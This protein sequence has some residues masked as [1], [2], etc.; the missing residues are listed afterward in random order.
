[1]KV[2]ALWIY[3]RQT[4][5]GVGEL[6]KAKSDLVW[7]LPFKSFTSYFSFKQDWAVIMLMSVFNFTRRASICNMIYVLHY[8]MWLI[9]FCNIW[10]FYF[11]I[12]VS[13]VSF[14]HMSLCHQGHPCGQSEQNQDQ[15]GLSLQNLT[16]ILANT[17]Y[18]PLRCY[19]ITCSLMQ[20]YSD[21]PNQSEWGCTQSATASC[22]FLIALIKYHK[23]QCNTI[24]TVIQTSMN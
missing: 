24:L 5:L 1:M 23:N 7:F 20:K 15:C 12:L 21:D 22:C 10:A 18:K 6:K 2:T 16:E 11:F 3:N 4:C 19:K 13:G 9:K 8:F 14:C 17:F